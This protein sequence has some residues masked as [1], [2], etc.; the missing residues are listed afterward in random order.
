MGVT[1]HYRGTVD[2]LERI[3]EMEDRVVDLAFALGGRATVWRSY[4]DHDPER[5][6]RGVMI[7]MAPGHETLGL[8]VS[9]EGHLTPLW[10]IEEAEKTPFDKPPDCFVKTQF[11]SIQGHVAIV[12]LLDALRQSY[13]SNLE[14]SDEGEYYETRDAAKLAQKMQSLARAVESLTEG[15]REHGLSDEAA[16]DPDIVA[17][18]IQRVAM[19]V[20]EKMLGNAATTSSATDADADESDWREPSLEEE[21][22]TMDR[23]R[24]QNQLRSERMIRRISEG[25][26]LGMTT[27]EAFR[28]AMQ[29]EGLSEPDARDAEAASQPDESFDVHTSPDEAWRQSLPANPLDDNDDSDSRDDH[30]AVERAQRFLSDIMDLAEADRS[31]GDFAS[32]ACRGAMDIVGGLVQATSDDFDTRT[33]RALAI[34]QLK[35]ALAGHA[36]AR[37]A[38]FALRSSGSISDETSQ[39][40]D[41]HLAAIL[42]SIHQLS[43]DAWGEPAFDSPLE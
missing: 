6:V 22:E 39:R 14:A 13:C 3:E 5:V 20:H 25:T 19:L 24:R 30:P 8:L 38:I 21:V 26:A 32:L 36:F 9:P 18:R 17:S 41:D 4:A 28:L 2:D 40:L 37:G 10:Q 11:G 43:S 31:P 23:Y 29:E 12:H 34:T 7:D 33:G 16:E 35:R 1:I 42:N 27:E 15:L